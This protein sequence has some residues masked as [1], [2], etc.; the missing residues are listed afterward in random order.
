MRDLARM[1]TREL[2]FETATAQR[3]TND[4]LRHIAQQNVDL[5][6][7]VK[8]AL[9]P[10]LSAEQ[11]AELEQAVAGLDEANSKLDAAVQATRS[12]P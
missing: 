10:G 1:D 5:A 12:S 6:K 9:S 8:S 7:L 2:A 11:I 3:E 4:R